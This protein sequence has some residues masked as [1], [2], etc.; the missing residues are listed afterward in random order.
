L[1]PPVVP[2]PRTGGGDT[3]MTNAS[4][5]AANFL[6]SEARIALALWPFSARSLKS[7]NGEN[8]TAEFGAEVKVAPSSP[9]I[10]TA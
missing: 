5:M 9:I 8:T 1:K 3:P 6:L 7:S 10:G 2:I 4:W